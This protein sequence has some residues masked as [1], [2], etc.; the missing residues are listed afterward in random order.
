MDVLILI[1][2][3]GVPLAATFSIVWFLKGLTR[4]LALLLVFGLI[5]ALFA[6][7]YS[8]YLRLSHGP[9]E[10]GMDANFDL[11]SAWGLAVFSI[12]MGIS[13]AIGALASFIIRYIVSKRSKSA[14]LQRY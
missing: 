2:Y 10:G 13:A 3:F 14:K 9:D 1:G 4:N 8:D 11:E 7:S 12:F 6:Y 5:G